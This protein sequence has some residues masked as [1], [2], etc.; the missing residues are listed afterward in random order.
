MA[1]LPHRT[2]RWALLAVPVATM[3]AQYGCD[4]QATAPPSPSDIQ[5][6]VTPAQL[7]LRLGASAELKAVI[8]D[9]TGR[10]LTNRSLEW[11][12]SAPEIA[13]VSPTGVVT[14]RDVGT[15]SISARSDQG[16]GFARVVVPLNFRLPLPQAVVLTEQGTPTDKCPEHEGG[17]RHSGSRDCSH[18][19][20][21]R[22]SLDLADPRQWAGSPV[23][24]PPEVRIAADGIIAS[25]CLQ[26]APITC[27]PDGPYVV[28]DHPGGFTSFYGHLE[29]ESVTLRRKT[30]VSQGD[31]LGR[32]AAGGGH[33]V[34]WVHFEIRYNNQGAN[35]ASVLEEIDLSGRRFADY[36]A[37]Q[38]Y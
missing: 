3:L 35:A 31:P 12:S 34:P 24:L 20:V 36:K 13:E 15:A 22:Y 19:G 10:E 21:S 14:A 29:P 7:S 23:D 16:I 5:I 9:R 2:S 18:S 32:M 25:V 27:G 1:R 4:G 38:A 17:L 8:T 11:S 26:P 6:S 28:V 33:P 37:G 30:A